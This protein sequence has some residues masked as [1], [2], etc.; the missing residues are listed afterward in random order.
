MSTEPAE[1]TCAC[2][3]GAG[4]YWKPCLL[5]FSRISPDRRAKIRGR[6]IREW[7]RGRRAA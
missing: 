3:G 7:A 5:H 1:K 2:T 4:P 6:M